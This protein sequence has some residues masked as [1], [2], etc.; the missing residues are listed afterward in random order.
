MLAKMAQRRNRFGRFS[1][2]RSAIRN[3]Q[4]REISPNIRTS[5]KELESINYDI[6]RM[7]TINQAI[8]LKYLGK[9]DEMDSLIEKN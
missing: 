1:P 2:A 7:I 3:T 9:K 5:L 4:R 8:A 6:H